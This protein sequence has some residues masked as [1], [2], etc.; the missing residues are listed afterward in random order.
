MSP[1]SEHGKYE[2][3]IEDL[4]TTACHALRVRLEKRGN[5]TWKKRSISK[6][7]EGDASYYIENAKRVV[8]KLNIDLESD[9]PPD[10]VVEIDVTS[11]S[12]HKLPTY[13]A[14]A[15]PEIWR[16]DGRNCRFYQLIEGAYAETPASRFLPGLT[17]QMLADA[18]DL[19]NT[20]GQDEARGAFRRKLRNQMRK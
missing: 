9:P 1:G 7:V 19:S 14:L 8:G 17:G 6:G 2:R 18:I 3:L 12:L 11:D 4:V 10:I 13:A 5:A 20:R 15:V 16:Y